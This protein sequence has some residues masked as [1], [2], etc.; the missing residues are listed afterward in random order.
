MQDSG[1]WRSGLDRE[2]FRVRAQAQAAT[3]AKQRTKDSSEVRRSRDRS[4]SLDVL[5]VLAALWVVMFHWGGGSIGANHIPTITRLGYMGVDVF[6]MLSGAVIIHT[7]LYRSWSDFAKRRFLR[8]YPVYF[9][10]TSITMAWVLVKGQR[11]FDPSLILQPTGLEMWLG[12]PAIVSV[13]WT[14]HYEVNFYILV[15]LFVL[16]MKRLD[17]EMARRGVQVF[18]VVLLITAQVDNTLVR[19]L[20]L[21]PYGAL[22]AFGAIAGLTTSVDMVKRNLPTILFAGFLAYPVV[23]D[24]V[25]QKLGDPISQGIWAVGI[26]CVCTVFL[27]WDILR[28]S[29]TNAWPRVRTVVMTLSLMTYPVYLIH[30]EFGVRFINFLIPRGFEPVPAYV[31]AGVVLLL[32]SWLSVRFYEPRARS[33]IRRLF[34]WKRT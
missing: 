8:L 21:H 10:V 13:A 3:S 31:C 1:V 22:F 25:S 28:K 30:H 24:R 11:D 14:L 26:L 17:E 34:A 16:L 4:L 20:T 9:I 33:G 15:G 18:L 19:I 32:I 29:R 12:Y 27:F 2:R 23:V 7:A 6:F 5:R